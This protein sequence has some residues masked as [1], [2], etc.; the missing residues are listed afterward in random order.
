MKLEKPVTLKEVADLLQINYIGNP[1]AMI[2]GLNEIHKV[3]AGDITF[4]DI[5]KYYAKALQSKATFIIINKE[6]ECPTGKGLL[7]SDEPF[8]D[9]N[10]LVLRYK[11][12]DQFYTGDFSEADDIIIGKNTVIHPGAVIANH[13]KI[14][15]N[16]IIYPNTTVYPE[17]EIGNSVIIHSNC[18]IGGDAF[19]YKNYKTHFEKLNT[20]GK[21][22]IEDDVEIGACCTIDRGV[23]GITLIGKGSR[24]DNQIQIGHGVIVGERCLFASQVGIGGKTIIGNDVILWGQVGVTKDITIGHNAVVLAQS[25]IS[26]SIKGDTVYFGT[27]AEEAKRIYKELACLRRLP[28]I[29]EQLPRPV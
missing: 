27:P 25:G 14:G 6:V 15:D 19:Y 7:I 12:A 3:E 8:R 2:T 26:K 23:S 9:Y 20:C 5:Q 21:T 4:V 11:K 24:L 18:V 29:I 13:V 10:K 1:D 17:T 22:I 16:C 28:E